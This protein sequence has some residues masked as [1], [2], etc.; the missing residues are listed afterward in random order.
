MEPVKADFY[1]AP[2]GNDQWSGLLAAP[3]DQKT[4]GPFA[5]LERARDAVRGLR[6]KQSPLERPVVVHVRGGVYRREQAFVLRP[7][8]SGTEA[9]PTVYQSY[10]GETAVVSGGRAITGWKPGGDGVWT[11]ELPEVK[12]GRWYF[13]QLF[14]NGQR[15][16]RPRLPKE[17]TWTV[18]QTPKVDTSGWVGSLPASP[19]E[20]AKRS[21][22]FRPGDLRP[23]WANL[24]DVEVVVLQFWME[25]RLRI[26]K[27]DA[28]KNVVLCTGGSWRPLTWSWG[29]YVD[30][31]RE[32]FDAPGTW[33]LDRKTGVL[34]YRPLPGEEM[35]KLE[36]VSPVTEQLVRFE[37]DAT[38]GR[39]VRDVVFRGLTFCHTNWQLPPEGFAH[40]QAE[41]PAPAAI[42]A[43]G[44][45]ACRIEQ[46]ELSHLGAWGIELRRGCRD[47]TIARSTFRDVAAGAIKIGE[48]ETCEEDAAETRSTVVS[49]NRIL[50]AGQD[51]LG[52]PGIWIGQSGANTISHNEIAG[53]LMWGVSVGWNWSYFPLNRARDNVVEFNHVHH[54][55]TGILGAHAGI[56]ALGTSPGTVI[57]NN[58]VHH[59]FHAERW[60]GAGEGIILDN[61][62]CGILVENNVVHDAVAGGFGT[63]FNCF[64]NIILN[65]IFAYGEEYQLTVYGDAPSGRPQPK[66]ELF[67]RNIVIWKDGPLIKEKDWPGFSTLWDYNLYF[68]EGGEPVAFMKY[69]FDEWK[70]KGLDEHSVLADPMFVDAAK[71]DFSL[72]PESPAL[73]LGFKPIDISR[74]GPR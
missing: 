11:V 23:D 61:G 9:S 19:D 39:A 2:G 72:K 14:V 17:G 1:V 21:F 69:S 70:A 16:A 51:F 36:V 35:D 48:P 12:A 26:Q 57:R 63:N 54:I 55:G 22:Q 15:R 44:A 56:Y 7:E 25:A 32:A 30:N 71:R 53:P 10:P 4:D 24:D 40:P 64:G 33:Y 34:A 37:G 41:I 49:D 47:N 8:D 59:V 73:K 28:G 60:A 74:V 5:T 42:H 20:W 45:A 58:H 52:A 27:I 13:R 62:C 18:A 31:V 67:A 3:N 43:D 6:S 29:Y 65:N 68:R 38:A 46:C 66:G 50:D